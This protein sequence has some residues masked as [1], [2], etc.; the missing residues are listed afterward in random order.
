[1]TFWKGQIKADWDSF[2]KWVEKGRSLI[3]GCQG[4]RH[5]EGSSNSRFRNLKASQCLRVFSL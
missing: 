1:M 2:E 4:G 5:G 3:F